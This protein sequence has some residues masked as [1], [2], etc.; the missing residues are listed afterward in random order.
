MKG[1]IKK[2]LS[3]LY[4]FNDIIFMLKSSIESIYILE[5]SGMPREVDGGEKL[6]IQWFRGFHLIVTRV[7]LGDHLTSPLLA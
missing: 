6:K 7:P 5:P 2:S 3:I 1:T 4:F